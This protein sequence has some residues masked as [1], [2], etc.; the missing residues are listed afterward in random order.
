[1]S[2]REKI[3]LKYRSL[4]KDQEEFYRLVEDIP[5]EE[6]ILSIERYSYIEYL[7]ESRVISYIKDNIK[8]NNYQIRL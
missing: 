4:F 8:R 5:K 7:L 3:Y 1:M 2:I 6:D